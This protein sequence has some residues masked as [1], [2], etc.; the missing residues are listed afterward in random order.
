MG[1]YGL[2]G[3]LSAWKMGSLTTDQAVGQ[4]LQLME[5]FDGRIGKLEQGYQSLVLSPAPTPTRRRRRRRQ[6]DIE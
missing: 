4:I 3:V 5:E 6:T 2:S 1:T